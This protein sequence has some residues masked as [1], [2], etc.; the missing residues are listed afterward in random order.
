[1]INVLYFDLDGVF[2][3]LGT[4]VLGHEPFKWDAKKNGK[5]VI[6]IVN[7][8]PSVCERLP[9][10]EDMLHVVNTSLDSIFIL[11]NQLDSWIPYTERW[12][13]KKLKIPYQVV[14][15]SGPDEKL[16]FLQKG[17]ILVEDY[18]LFKSY[19]QIALVNRNYNMV[20]PNPKVRIYGAPGLKWVIEQYGNQ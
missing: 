8:D 16:K 6:Q 7:E 4:S 18:P 10:Y 1:M 17:D 14:Y 2:R 9:A 3:I 13:E 5:S 11:T 19:D 12:L 20:V 15:T